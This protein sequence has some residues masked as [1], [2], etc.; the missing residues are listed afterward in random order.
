MKKVM[1]FGTFDGLHKGH[2]NFFQQA[3]K[4]GD[5]L[6]IIVARDENVK[7]VKGRLPK[8]GE[9]ERLREVKEAISD[10]R[11]SDKAILGGRKDP[12]QVIRKYKPDVIC[13]GYD[14]NSFSEGLKSKFP[15]VKIVRLK[16]YRADVYKSSKINF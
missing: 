15:K 12:Y 4:Y 1:V 11:S 10:Q 5:E 16:P 9:G 8:L 2:L 13:L 7:K 6:I 3:K 14:Q